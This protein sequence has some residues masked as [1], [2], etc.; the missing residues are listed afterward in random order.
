VDKKDE[1]GLTAALNTATTAANKVD[2]SK[3]STDGVMGAIGSGVSKAA[4][5][6]KDAAGKAVDATKDAAGKA[7]DAT[8]DAAGK[9]A[10]AMKK[11]TPTPTPKKN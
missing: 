10:D 6:T 9:A 4:D 5:T 1:K 7:A 11:G 3:L 2:A 8:K